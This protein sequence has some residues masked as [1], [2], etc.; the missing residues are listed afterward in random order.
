MK[1]FSC[2]CKT[3]FQGIHCT[4]RTVD[5]LSSSS[6]ELCGHG[7]CVHTNDPNSYRCICDQGWTSNGTSPACIVDIN[8]CETPSPHFSM[9]P[10]VPCINL[11]GSLKKNNSRIAIDDFVWWISIWGSYTCGACP[12][13]FSGNGHYCKGNSKKMAQHFF[14]HEQ[15]FLTVENFVV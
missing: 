11:P 10:E 4:M 9:D 13:G 1:I 5:C 8:E 2:Q 6:Y 7:V 12:H 14:N 3:G 15:W